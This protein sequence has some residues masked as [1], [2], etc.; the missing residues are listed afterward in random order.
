MLRCY[1]SFGA[2]ALL[3]VASLYLFLPILRDANGASEQRLNYTISLLGLECDFSLHWWIPFILLVISAWL[4]ALSKRVEFRIWKSA[5]QEFWQRFRAVFPVTPE[6]MDE[7]R[8][9]AAARTRAM[10]LRWIALIGLEVG[11]ILAVLVILALIEPVMV[12][13]LLVTAA[14]LVLMFRRALWHRAG[15]SPV[16]S[17]GRQDLDQIIRHRTS[18]ANAQQVFFALMPIT[19]LLLLTLRRLQVVTFDLAG[20]VFLSVL[21]AALGNACASG[22]HNLLHLRRLDLSILSLWDHLA[23]GDAETFRARLLASKCEPL[24][25]DNGE[26]KRSWRR[27]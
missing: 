14:T 12:P 18:M 27:A 4:L 17:K 22:M 7:R 15:Q 3:F 21:V 10:A 19:I 8:V 2:S 6:D 16:T 23:R 13:L 25:R 20:L 9:E 11:K 1:V 24:T 5:H 26:G